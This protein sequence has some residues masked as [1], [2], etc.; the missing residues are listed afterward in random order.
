MAV[1]TFQSITNE[2]KSG[3]LAPV[4]ILHGEEG[5]YIDE[6]VKLF[7]NFL[8]EADR[9]FNQYVLY[10]PEVQAGQ[11]MDLSLIHI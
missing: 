1:P 8:P 2:I 7:E 11:V 5:Y 9:E 6:L 4:Y 3:K 10:A